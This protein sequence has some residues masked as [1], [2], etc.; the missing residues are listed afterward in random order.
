[1]I[2]QLKNAVVDLVQ[3]ADKSDMK[4]AKYNVGDIARYVI[5][6]V[7]N[8][9]DL[10]SNLKLQKVLYFIQAKFLT[11]IG[12]PCFKEEIEAWSMGVV[13]PSVYNEYKRYGAGCI[14]P[15]KEF[16]VYSDDI[17]ECKYV[18]YS[19]D[20]I[21][22]YD[23]KAIN[24]I[25]NKCANYSDFQLTSI[26]RNQTPYIKAYYTFKS[27]RRKIVSKDDIYDFFKD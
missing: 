25:I 12:Y 24:E 1:M 16:F 4:E 9:D 15:V 8:N 20:V 19:D 13:I 27:L 7:N 3:Q 22:D 18:K 14:L 21:D 5:N 11:D 26:T 10:I 23:K 2:I 17:F 6:Y